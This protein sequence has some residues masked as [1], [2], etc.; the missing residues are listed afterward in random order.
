MPLRF[1]CGA[2]G[3]I[4]RRSGASFLQKS[5]PALRVGDLIARQDLEGHS[6]MKPRILR[7]E[8][9][10]HGT[11]ADGRKNFVR[12]E[13]IAGRERHRDDRA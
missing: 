1:S 9:L 4:Q 10:T 7:P 3:M 2:L 13:L 12:S 6:A 8:N 5:P 11:R